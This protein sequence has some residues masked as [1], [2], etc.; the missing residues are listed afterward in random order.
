MT[1]TNA[2]TS[3]PGGITALDLEASSTGVSIAVR[4]GTSVK[5]Y[6]NVTD[7]AATFDE[8]RPGTFDLA[9]TASG[10]VISLCDFSG[11]R[12]LSTWVSP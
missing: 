5:V 7:A 8:V 4:I 12:T 2:T 3:I 11:N 9:R 6:K 10:I 1:W